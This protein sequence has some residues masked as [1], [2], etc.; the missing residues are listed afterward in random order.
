MN[1]DFHLKGVVLPK[2]SIFFIIYSPTCHSRTFFLVQ[3]TKEK[4][5]NV[6]FFFFLFIQWKSKKQC[7]FGPHWIPWYGQKQKHPSK[8]IILFSTEERKAWNDMR[9]SKLHNFHFGVDFLTKIFDWVYCSSIY[10]KIRNFVFALWV[11]YNVS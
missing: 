6:L 3:N 10:T 5:K 4:F 8:L 11:Y 2:I 9:V 1:T 7:C